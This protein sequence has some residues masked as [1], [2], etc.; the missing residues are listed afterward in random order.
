[1]SARADNLTRIGAQSSLTVGLGHMLLNVADPNPGHE[2]AYTRWYEDDHFFAAA[3]MAPFV[4]AGRRWVAPFELR[5][6]Q[7]RRA[8][9]EFDTGDAGRYAAT[10]WIAPGHLN[11]Y[12]AWAAGTGPQLDAQ[13][14]HFPNR[15]LA[16]VSFADRIGSVYR[17]R[18][19]PRDLFSL[20]D[21]AAGM[22]LQIVD[23]DRPE[24]REAVAGWL[25]D[26]LLP[27]L[28]ARPNAS[29]TTALVFRGAADTS[30]MRPALQNLQRRSDN[31]GRRLIIVWLTDRCPRDTWSA[32]FADRPEVFDRSGRAVVEWST[33]FVPVRM[34]TNRYAEE[35]DA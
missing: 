2:V 31:D 9:G 33:P 26:E 3:M 30:A 32:E 21:P 17:D 16:F 19:V 12:I 13:G 34:G 7:Y 6:L 4:F 35:L 8:G 15:R 20:I 29:A 11:D 28:I 24:D 23:V 22:V 14:R 10:Y 18:D 1:M 25:V 5:S 27:Q